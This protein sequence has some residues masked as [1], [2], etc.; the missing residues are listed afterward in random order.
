M[1][2]SGRDLQQLCVAAK[3]NT[4]IN[5]TIRAWIDADTDAKV[6]SRMIDQW[7]ESDFKTAFNCLRQSTYPMGST[8]I[9]EGAEGI[10]TVY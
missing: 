6:D 8:G 10:A 2:I 4:Q 7:I 3:F 5:R 1:D 9:K